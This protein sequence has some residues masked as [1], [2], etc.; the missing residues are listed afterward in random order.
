MAGYLF[1][2]AADAALDRIWRD[3]AES[4]GEKQA[5][6]YILGLHNHLERLCETKAIW[7]ELPKDL[8]TAAG[9]PGGIYVSRYR[10]HLMF[11]R[12]LPSGKLGVL[13]ILH[14][15]MDIPTRLAEELARTSQV[16]SKEN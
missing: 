16:Q 11:F 10:H 5:A 12:G 4:W 7:R 3:T 6:A 9:L 2:P 1:H 8:I 15:R 14:E 13:S